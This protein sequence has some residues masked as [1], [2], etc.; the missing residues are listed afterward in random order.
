MN[1]Y[2]AQVNMGRIKA[3][4]D[5]VRMAGFMTR[6]DELNALAD[7]SPG[8]I[9]RL[10]TNEG[11]ATYFRPYPDDDRILLN[12]SVWE[13]IE[14]LK[15]YV[16]RTVHAELLR[17]RHEWFESFT[18]AYMALWWVP[19]GHFPSIDEAKKRVAHLDAHGPTQFAF[20]FKATFEPDEEFQKGIDWSSFTPCSVSA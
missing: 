1:Y 16:Y 9:W 13:T 6:L 19:V 15:H 4:L 8:F 10:Q 14:A 17:C 18:G 2:I 5:D 12:M 11:N 3:P 7:C 20:T